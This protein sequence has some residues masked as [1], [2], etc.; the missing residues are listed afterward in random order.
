V[1]KAAVMF[2]INLRENFSIFLLLSL[3]SN[4]WKEKKIKNKK[5]AKE[6]V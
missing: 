5:R 2:Q 6:K 1:D 3:S 4:G